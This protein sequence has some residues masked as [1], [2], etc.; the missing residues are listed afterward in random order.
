LAVDAKICGLTRA[1]DAVLAVAGGAWRLGVVFAGGP[2]RVGPT[3][4]REIVAAAGGVPVIGVYQSHDVGAI[5]ELTATTGLKGA[6]LHGD[7]TAQDAG[8]LRGAGLEVWRVLHL[9]AE[10]PDSRLLQA[11]IT[12]ADVLL[13]EPR[14]PDRGAGARVVLD[15]SLARVARLLVQGC[16]VALA[17][18]LTPDSVAEAIRVVGPDVVDV[19]SGVERA[20]GFKDPVKLARFLEQV[21]DAY[22]SG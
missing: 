5:L 15:L 9:D 18:G 12:G 21:R 11:A 14:H 8:A 3:Q 2:R 20:P 16:R 13:L 10:L 6:Q 22:P 7:Y 4:A 17:G 19:S 1:E